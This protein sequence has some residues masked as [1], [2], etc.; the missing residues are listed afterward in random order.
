MA[1]VPPGGV[2]IS[3]IL[4]RRYKAGV[5]FKFATQAASQP[6]CARL[7]VLVPKL[8]ESLFSL[9]KEH[10][11]SDCVDARMA[12]EVSNAVLV[13]R[14]PLTMIKHKRRNRNVVTGNRSES[15]VVKQHDVEKQRLAVC[16]RHAKNARTKWRAKSSTG[17]TSVSL[18]H[19]TLRFGGGPP[20]TL[21]CS[22]LRTSHRK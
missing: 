11:R 6:D 14:T 9:R 2:P 16:A 3:V 12:L 7:F 13:L 5:S 17:T 1:G 22:K 10:E 18:G 8:H 21:M 15:R 19:C 20:Q 4:I